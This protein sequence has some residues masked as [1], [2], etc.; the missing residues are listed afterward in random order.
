[1]ATAGVILLPG[2]KVTVHQ[3][4]FAAVQTCWQHRV[5][6][7]AGHRGCTFYKLVPLLLHEAKLVETRVSSENLFRD[8][9]Q[10]SSATQ[11][12]LTEA[13]EM[14]QDS[15]Q[16]DTFYGCAVPCMLHASDL[17]LL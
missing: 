16:L 10:S 12:K 6:G 8:V 15:C 9:R 13:W 11:K 17:I 3:W 1:M 4:L 2:L 5:N 14:M 7:K